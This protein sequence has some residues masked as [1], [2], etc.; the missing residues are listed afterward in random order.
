MCRC[1]HSW[2]TQVQTASCRLL[3]SRLAHVPASALHSAH[4]EQSATPARHFNYGLIQMS[5]TLCSAAQGM[6]DVLQWLSVALPAGVAG[7]RSRWERLSAGAGGNST[8]GADAE[9][10]AHLDGVLGLADG[11]LA[12]A[13][14]VMLSST[15]LDAVGAEQFQA[16]RDKMRAFAKAPLSWLLTHLATLVPQL[17]GM[18]SCLIIALETLK[19]CCGLYTLRTLRT[20]RRKAGSGAHG[21]CKAHDFCPGLR[22]R[23]DWQEREAQLC[24]RQ[25][26]VVAPH[27][28]AGRDWRKRLLPSWI[29]QA[30]LLG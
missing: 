23:L 1:A 4:V 16:S 27:R 11:T 22:R 2:L 3:T 13:S 24:T 15:W 12:L 7:L 18:Q 9:L 20:G 5:A 10:R 21:G 6:Q 14:V 26:H 30:D 29:R 25:R 19:E 8:I 17:S 28:D